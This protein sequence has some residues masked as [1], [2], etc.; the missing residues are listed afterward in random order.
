VDDQDLIHIM[1][2][3]IERYEAVQVGAEDRA[4]V[5]GDVGLHRFETGHEP[6]DRQGNGVGIPLKVL[7]AD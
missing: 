7:V 2:Q 6:Q 5:H 4:L 3:V 1:K